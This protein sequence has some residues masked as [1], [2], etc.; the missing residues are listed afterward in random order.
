[1]QPSKT[2]WEKILNK[3][4]NFNFEKKKLRRFGKKN[5]QYFQSSQKLG[6][7]KIAENVGYIHKIE[8]NTGTLN[9]LPPLRME[10]WGCA[11]MSILT[12]GAEHWLLLLII[13]KCLTWQTTPQWRTPLLQQPALKKEKSRYSYSLLIYLPTYLRVLFFGKEKQCKWGGRGGRFLASLGPR[14]LSLSLIWGGS[15]K[16]LSL[17]H[18]PTRSPAPTW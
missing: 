15:A 18:P 17:S 2:F 14:Q 12:L 10:F 6:K 1:L 5:L 13:P 3:F 4:L 7:K 11:F 8:R 9:Y 16:H